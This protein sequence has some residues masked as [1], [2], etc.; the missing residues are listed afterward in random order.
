MIVAALAVVALV[1]V[2]S[3]QGPRSTGAVSGAPS[4]RTNAAAALAKPVTIELTDA[5]LEDAVQFI[6]DFAALEIDAAWADD[7]GADG[8]DKDKTVTLSVKD[9]RVVDLLERLL[10]K[11]S[12]EFERAT[13]QFARDGAGIEIG[14]RSRLNA[15]AYM[16]I[17][18]VNDLLYVVPNFD[19]AP[20]LDLDQVLNQGQ[21]GGGGGGGSIFEDNEDAEGSGPTSEELVEQ[22][23]TI[24]TENIEPEQWQDNGG[25]GA[26]IRFYNGAFLIR[27][28]EYIHRQLDPNSLPRRR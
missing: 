26:T 24:I 1:P 12:S 17:Y 6:R 27:A 4:G 10:E 14:P 11:A 2:V 23:Q 3:A 21:Q 13:W 15:K 18:D 19:D 20:R 22:L 16:K 25:S 9:A 5:R 28:P 7:S 8:L